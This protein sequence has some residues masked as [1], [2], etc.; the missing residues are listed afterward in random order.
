MAAGCRS[1]FSAYLGAVAGVAD[2]TTPFPDQRRSLPSRAE[3]MMLPSSSLTLNP[4]PDSGVTTAFIALA[5]TG[6]ASA[7]VRMILT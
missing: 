1:Y 6:C 7:E 4:P 3:E 2:V 5:I